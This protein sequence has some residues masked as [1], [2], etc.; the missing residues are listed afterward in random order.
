L[1]DN[2]Y[3]EALEIRVRTTF[4]SCKKTGRIPYF[5][6]Q[7]FDFYVIDHLNIKNWFRQRVNYNIYSKRVSSFKSILAK[8]LGVFILLF[9]GFIILSYCGYIKTK[10][11][12]GG[13]RPAEL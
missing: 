9:I 1:L 4:Y 13:F 2:G 3:V 11:D 8:V 6:N 7:S 5:S 10:K 12:K